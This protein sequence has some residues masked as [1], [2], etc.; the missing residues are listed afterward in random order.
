V[1]TKFCVMLFPLILVMYILVDLGCMKWD[2]F[3]MGRKILISLRK[4]EEVLE[5]IR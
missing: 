4:R 5:Y 3:M 1:K 2:F